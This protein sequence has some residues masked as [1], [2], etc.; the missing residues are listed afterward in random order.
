M[1]QDRSTRFDHLRKQGA[2]GSQVGALGFLVSFLSAFVTA[3]ALVPG[4]LALFWVWML[5]LTFATAGGAICTGLAQ[6]N[7]SRGRPE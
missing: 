2:D 3:A 4:G 7:N 1:T 5:I 6:W